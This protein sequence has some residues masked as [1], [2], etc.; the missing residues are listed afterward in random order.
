MPLQTIDAGSDFAQ[1]AAEVIAG[2]M[3]SAIRQHGSCTVGLSGGSTPKPV[4]EAL[5]QEAIDWSRVTFFLVDDRCVSPDHPDSNQQLARSSIINVTGAASVFPDTS[6]PPD[7]SA[8]EYG[9]RLRLLWN[10]HLPD[11][12]IVGM[13][14]DGHIA[15][16][17]PPLAEN[18]MDDTR[19]V[20]HTTTDTFA[21]HDRITLTL[22]PITA[23]E[24]H[25]FL[26]KGEDKKQ[27]W[28]EMMDSA[29]NEQRW[30]AK[31]IVDHSHVT[32]VF[33]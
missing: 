31:R 2:I 9:S 12:M 20:A 28:E 16:L 19:L 4:Y 14:P 21:V 1:K 25:V 7:E 18:L 5:A 15:S 32:V 13:G 3:R 17:F 22:N 30:P 8:Q 6:L 27:L 11:V 29:E 26:L 33:G 24:H 23:A 10:N